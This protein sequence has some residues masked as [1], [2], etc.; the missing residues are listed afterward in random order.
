[1]I[2][3]PVFPT[4]LSPRSIAHLGCPLTPQVWLLT[5]A[6]LHWM[7]FFWTRN[8]LSLCC[9][10]PPASLAQACTQ[11]QPL[12]PQS[13]TAWSIRNFIADSPGI[14][15]SSLAQK[16]QVEREKGC[17]F[18]EFRATPVYETLEVRSCLTSTGYTHHVLC[19]PPI[20]SQTKHRWNSMIAVSRSTCL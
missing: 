1:M 12:I 17:S 16:Q 11:T 9:Y 20:M 2:G 8:Q 19:F 5:T 18:L 10:S 3:S 6:P 7:S 13:K 4:V 14:L 15:Q